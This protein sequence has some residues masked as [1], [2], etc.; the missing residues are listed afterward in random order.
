M[1]SGGFVCT[2]E[3]KDAYNAG[4]PADDWD[5]YR[6]PPPCHCTRQTPLTSADR[7]QATLMRPDPPDMP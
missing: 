3:V 4:E 6:L 7:A 2:E 1:E 5:A